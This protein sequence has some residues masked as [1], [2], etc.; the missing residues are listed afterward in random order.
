MCEN[1]LCNKLVCVY[2]IYTYCK[3][4]IIIYYKC[5]CKKNP[6]SNPIDVDQFLGSIKATLDSLLERYTGAEITDKLSSSILATLFRQQVLHSLRSDCFWGFF[7]TRFYI[8]VQ[9][10]L[11]SW[12]IILLLE[13]CFLDI[14][15]SLLLKSFSSLVEL[16][17]RLSTDTGDIFSK[18][19]QIL[20]TTAFQISP[21]HMLFVRIKCLQYCL[22]VELYIN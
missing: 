12:Q 5:L 19:S 8:R 18:V 14:P 22:D 11:C 3:Y 16:L 13:L 10:L 9:Y 17:K 7:V 21:P 2:I 6:F 15:H 20:E 1:V 4:I